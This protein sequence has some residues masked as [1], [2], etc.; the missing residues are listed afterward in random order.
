MSHFDNIS[1]HC[2]VFSGQ[3]RCFQLQ[4]TKPQIRNA[5]VLELH[6]YNTVQNQLTDTY[7]EHIT[8]SYIK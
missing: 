4:R 3:W 1:S 7:G 5:V 2:Y 8:E 6:E